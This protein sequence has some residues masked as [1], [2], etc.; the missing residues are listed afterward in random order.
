M[1][2]AEETIRRQL[3]ALQD[4]GYR[5][6]Q[7]RLLPNIPPERVIGVRTPALRRLAGTL[8]GTPLAQ[9]FLQSL[10]HPYYEEN[11]LHAFLIERMRGYPQALAAVQAFLPW[12]DNWATCDQMSP[13]AFAGHQ[14]ELLP[15]IR[16]WLASE[17][18]YT[19]R[20][21]IG[22]LMRWYLGEAFSSEYPALVAAVPSGEYYISMMQ[23]W[24][25]AT[26]LAFQWDAV[27]PYLEQGKLERTTHNR[28]I[29]KAVE[30][31]RIT[32]AQKT[33]LRA[34]RRR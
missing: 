30:S 10:P 7:R 1:A 31:Y 8:A 13:K 33:C 16:R 6:F 14:A 18:V 15:V 12:V 34:L 29:Q 25:F 21:G 22:M 23:A 5:D 20:C 4:T 26:A 3:E 24:Y 19:V 2:S 9:D 32:D 28:A 17:H 11:N 27:L